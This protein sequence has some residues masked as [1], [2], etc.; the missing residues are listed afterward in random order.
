MLS[1]F[2]Y[3]LLLSLPLSLSHSFS[4]L[5]SLYLILFCLLGFCSLSL[6]PV[7]KAVILNVVVE[8]RCR[9]C[10]F[11]CLLILLSLLLLFLLVLLVVGTEPSIV[12]QPVARDS[13][14][15]AV[16]VYCLAINLLDNNFR[17]AS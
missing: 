3:F 1:R 10:C 9:Y 17:L 14:S 6:R 4:C 15:H 11:Y 5:P 7:K 12:T 8:R 16:R 13:H 2:F